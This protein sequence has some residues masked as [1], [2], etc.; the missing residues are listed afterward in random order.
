MK[1]LNYVLEIR[2][3][4][5]KIFKYGRP[6][7]L[8]SKLPG[9]LLKIELDFLER[10]SEFSE[11]GGTDLMGEENNFFIFENEKQ[12]IF[13]VI[14]Y[15]DKPCRIVSQMSKKHWTAIIQSNRS[16]DQLLSSNHQKYYKH[17]NL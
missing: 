10:W 2:S 8:V 1:L 7:M 15:F 13:E 4:N 11:G 6:T 3:K 16:N 9:D 5:K 14:F 17:Y 12:D